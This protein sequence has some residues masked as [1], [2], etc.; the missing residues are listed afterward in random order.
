MVRVAALG[1]VE[2]QVHAE[3]VAKGEKKIVDQLGRKRANPFLLDGQ[4][5][6]QKGSP[7]EI[8][9][10]I[11]QGF[12]ERH[13]GFAKAANAALIAQRGA[14]G[15]AQRQPHVFNRMM[16]VNLDITRGLEGEIKKSMPGKQLQHV[17]EKGHAGG[18][19][20][21]AAAI[22]LKTEPNVGF[23]CFAMQVCGALE[24]LLCCCCCQIC[25]C[26]LH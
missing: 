15:F 4:I 12:V 13:A 3:L 1:H 24:R 17:V 10:A 25:H 18:D 16:I 22:K 20:V 7:A 11:H 9:D 26:C 2:V 8:D 5:I 23:V 14:K 19:L 21:L 6:G